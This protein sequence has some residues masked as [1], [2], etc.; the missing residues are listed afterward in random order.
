VL[1]DTDTERK[2]SEYETESE[3]RK[4]MYE[5]D[6]NSTIIKKSEWDKLPPHPD[7]HSPAYNFNEG[8]NVDGLSDLIK[9]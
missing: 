9:G 4:S 8:G 2:L 7:R 1:F 5:Y 3:A 6:G